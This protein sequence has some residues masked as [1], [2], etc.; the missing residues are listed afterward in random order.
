MQPLILHQCKLVNKP[1]PQP[2]VGDFIIF[3]VQ[4]SVYEN[5]QDIISQNHKYFESFFY[6]HFPN[7][8]SNLQEMTAVLAL[9]FFMTFR[10]PDQHTAFLISLQT[11]AVINLHHAWRSYYILRGNPSTHCTHSQILQITEIILVI[12][13]S[14]ICSHGI[15]V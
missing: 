4:K 3:L 11:Q 13:E 7:H 14:C 5:Y 6:H 2:T 1:Q 9:A 12:D 8:H 15:L 10:A